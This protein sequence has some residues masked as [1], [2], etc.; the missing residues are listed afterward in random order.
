[1]CTNE[2]RKPQEDELNLT[3][4]D[5]SCLIARLDDNPDYPGILIYLQNPNGTE[6]L[7]CFAEFNSEKPPGKELCLGAY[8]SIED[9]TVYYDNYRKG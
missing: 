8:T 9:D 5:K 7:V 3:L 6:E 1:M 4:P 2:T